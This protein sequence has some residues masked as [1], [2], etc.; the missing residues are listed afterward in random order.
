MYS[1]KILIIMIAG[2]GLWGCGTSTSV[3]GLGDAVRHNLAVHII[4]PD[5]SR[6]R[7]ESVTSG[8]KVAKAIKR[9]QEGRVLKPKTLTL[10]G[11]ESSDTSN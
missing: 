10:K 3:N 11:T 7:M 2:L 6:D 9:Y 4:N 5:P 1:K 8:E